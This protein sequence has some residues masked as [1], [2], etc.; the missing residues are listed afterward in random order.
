MAMSIIKEP[1]EQHYGGHY[2]RLDQPRG[3][4]VSWTIKDGII[5]YTKVRYVAAGFEEPG[6]STPRVYYG[7]VLAQTDERITF[8]PITK[9]QARGT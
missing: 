7:R 5:V 1:S 6:D 8:E 4:D 2:W 3:R 9:K